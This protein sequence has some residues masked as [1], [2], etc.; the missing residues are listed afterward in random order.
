MTEQNGREE[1][2]RGK[3]TVI[4][5]GVAGGASCAA[6]LRRLDEKAR[7][8]MVER[9]PHISFANCGLPYH[10]SGVIEERE[11]LIVQT[12]EKFRS[13]FDVDVRTLTE[14]ASIDKEHK[15]VTLRDVTTDEERDLPY[16][17]LVLSP[18][19]A[20]FKPPIDGIDLPAV[21]VLRTIPDMDRII[22]ACDNSSVERVTVVGAGFIGLEVAENLAH[23]GLSVSVVEMGPQVMPGLDR[24]IAA[25]LTDACRRHG[26]EVLLSTRITAIEKS[27]EGLEVLTA[28]G[29]RRATDMVIMAV[30]VRPEVELARGA[31]LELG[32]RGGIAVDDTLRTSDPAIFAIGDAVEV[33]HRVT[34]ESGFMALAGPANRQGRMVA[35]VISGRER[36]YGGVLGTSI[37]SVFDTVAAC[38]GLSEKNARRLEIPH[39]VAWISGSSHASYYP[40]AETIT[41][42]AIFDPE[43]G[44]LLGAQ[45]FGGDGVDKRIDVLATAVAARMRV[46][47]LEELDLAYAPPF[48]S[49]KDPVNHL[50]AVA[51]GILHGEHPSLG[52][53]EWENLSEET[54]LIDVRSRAE[55]AAGSVPGAV[56]IPLDELRERLDEIPRHAPVVLLCKE[57]LRGYLATRILMQYDIRPRNLLGGYRL[58]HLANRGSLPEFNHLHRA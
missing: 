7:I 26:V 40:G 38:T 44:V 23:L 46:D 24:E 58:W 10:I 30:G 19:A 3:T 11:A 1:E 28:D 4:V 25:S 13:R 37:I 29:N 14:V 32:P 49:A 33:K 15:T 48:S 5:G 52:W 51:S 31:G 22:D 55:F 41:L 8:I 18:G 27:D 56:N 45:A 53:D 47:Q 42:K 43:E 9:G 54:R 12:P 6:R 57:G 50:G 20:P 39:R 36:T 17:H 16:D 34:G 2:S 21:H 35:D